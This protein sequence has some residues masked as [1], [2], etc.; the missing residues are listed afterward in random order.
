MCW[1]RMRQESG[2]RN[3]VIGAVVKQPLFYDYKSIKNWVL[4]EKF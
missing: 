1:K 2:E 4:G 3:K